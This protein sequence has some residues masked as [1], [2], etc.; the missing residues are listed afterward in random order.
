M[1]GSVVGAMRKVGTQGLTFEDKIWEMGAT[2]QRPLEMSKF[3][4]NNSQTGVLKCYVKIHENT[5]LK[6]SFGHLKVHC[7]NSK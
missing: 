4:E 3:L 1:E 7:Y 2:K 6:T 5:R